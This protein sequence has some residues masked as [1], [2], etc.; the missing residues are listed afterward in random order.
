MTNELSRRSLIA[1]GAAA[2]ASRA[3]GQTAASAPAI[4]SPGPRPIRPPLTGPQ[5]APP[6]APLFPPFPVVGSIEQLDPSLASL[7]DVTTPVEKIL[8]GFV[9]V[10]GPVWV[11]GKDGYL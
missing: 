10:E 3:F 5:V 2:I 11:G 9:W 8:E 4:A 7:I 1:I 6:A